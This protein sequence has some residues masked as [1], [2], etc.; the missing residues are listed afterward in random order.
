MPR[1]ICR[2]ILEIKSVR[3]ERLK[4]ITEEDIL[5]EGIDEMTRALISKYEKRWEPQCWLNSDAGPSY[6]LRCAEKALRNSTEE[7]DYIDGG[8]P[9]AGIETDILEYCETCGKM[10]ESSPLHPEDYLADENGEYTER[11]PDAEE[12]AMLASFN[13]GDKINREVFRTFWDSQCSAP[14]HQWETNPWVWV[15]DFERVQ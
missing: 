1:Q 9:G 13:S 4:S 8:Y 2:I 6:C 5:S 11:P 3:I 15:I 10:L 12:V 7:G 14:S